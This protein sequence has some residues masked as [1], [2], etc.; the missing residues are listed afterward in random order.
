MTRT[1]SKHT[2]SFAS[3]QK[4][5]Q[6][7]VGLVPNAM[8]YVRPDDPNKKLVEDFAYAIGFNNKWSEEVRLQSEHLFTQSH[9]FDDI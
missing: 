4:T 8:R 2:S 3:I 1:L 5:E 7:K 9:L 6:V